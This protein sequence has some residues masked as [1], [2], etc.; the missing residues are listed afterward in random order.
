MPPSEARTGCHSRPLTTTRRH[1]EN[2]TQK[3]RFSEREHGVLSLS[4]AS[5]FTQH[6]NSC[7]H[8]ARAHVRDTV[9]VCKMSQSPPC[10]PRHLM[11]YVTGTVK[12]THCSRHVRRLHFRY[13]VSVTLP[14]THILAVLTLLLSLD[15]GVF[16]NR[17]DPF[18]R[19][20]AV[21]VSRG[22]RGP[23]TSFSSSLSIT[24]ISRGGLSRS[25][26]TRP[27]T[28][29]FVAADDVARSSCQHA[30]QQS[31]IVG[32]GGTGVERGAKFHDVCFACLIPL[33][34]TFLPLR[35]RLRL[36]RPPPLRRRPTKTS[37]PAP[38]HP[39]PRAPPGRRSCPWCSLCRP[40]ARRPRCWPASSDSGGCSLP[41]TAGRQGPLPVARPAAS[42]CGLVSARLTVSSPS[43]RS[44][45]W[46]R[47]SLRVRWMRARNRLPP[48]EVLAVP[49]PPPPP[50]PLRPPRPRRPRGRRPLRL[51]SPESGR[52]RD[53]CAGRQVGRPGDSTCVCPAPQS[54]ANREAWEAGAPPLPPPTWGTCA[55]RCDASGR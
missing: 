54:P 22:G 17:Q 53:R 15:A 38:P 21:H 18:V 6:S 5:S 23:E 4:F 20:L 11:I 41:R 8:P 25:L 37:L 33:L 2:H 52:R 55:R 28:L 1:E 49:L 29:S 45:T 39:R 13:L 14:H 51:R 47:C 12:G 9:A 24:P 44:S 34:I 27:L 16:R 30:L 43:G 36:P 32:A 3:S 7:T 48:L 42:S 31:L 50:P 40:V 10:Q 46:I 35:P 26:I 19:Q